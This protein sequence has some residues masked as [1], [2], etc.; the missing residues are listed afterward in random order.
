MGELETYNAELERKKQEIQDI[1]NGIRDLLAVV[2]PDYRIIYVNKVFNE[3]FDI[4]IPK[5]CT[6]TRFF[7]ATPSRVRSVPA[8]GLADR[9]AG[10]GP[11]T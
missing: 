10:P 1:L 7:E 2:S 3:Y 4:L 5:G 6:A 9:Q 11:R 8:H